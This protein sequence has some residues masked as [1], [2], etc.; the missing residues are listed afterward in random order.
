MDNKPQLSYVSPKH[1][2][3]SHGVISHTSYVFMP[4]FEIHYDKAYMHATYLNKYASVF[5]ETGL[6]Y[7]FLLP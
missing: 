7:V 1:D 4:K 3:L 6:L 5:R 2:D